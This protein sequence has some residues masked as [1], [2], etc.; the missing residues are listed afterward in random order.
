MGGSVALIAATRVQ[1]PVDAVVELSGEADPTQL[2]GI[3]LNAGAAVQQLAVPTMFVVTNNEQYTSVDETR[4]MYHAA[5][6]SDK[7]LEVLRP[8]RW[9]AR[10]G[11]AHQR[12]W[13]GV[14]SVTTKVTEFITAH[15][16]S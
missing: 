5:K 15:T 13:R 4:A 6:T 12:K 2:L 3:P 14:S 8:V 16:R 7:R 11:V 9:S 10:V 1:P